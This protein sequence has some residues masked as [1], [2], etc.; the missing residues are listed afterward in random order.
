MKTNLKL[1]TKSKLLKNLLELKH[2]S[3]GGHKNSGYLFNNLIIFP[4]I[5]RN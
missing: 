3:K 2:M 4:S 1:P 5:A